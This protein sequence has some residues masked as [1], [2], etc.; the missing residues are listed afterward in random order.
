MLR[1]KTITLVCCIATAVMLVL[2]VAIWIGKAATGRNTTNEVGYE[3][4]FDKSY[5][6]TIDIEI[7]DW[8]GF[9]STATSEEYVNCNLIIDG[10]RINS[11]AIR[12]KGN[13]SLSSVASQGS[14][15]YSFKV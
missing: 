2:A 1:S 15:K 10:D 12:A 5:V 13:T 8:E 14:E 7:D 3:S 6:H 11:V 4:L 9:I